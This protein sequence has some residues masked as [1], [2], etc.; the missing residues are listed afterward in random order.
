MKPQQPT[1]TDHRSYEE[2]AL[3][4]KVDSIHGLT[5]GQNR[6]RGQA[7][8]SQAPCLLQQS[9]NPSGGSSAYLLCDLG[10]IYPVSG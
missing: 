3:Y 4:A 7:P 8:V 5:E 9:L 2:Q 10:N 6:A 1:E